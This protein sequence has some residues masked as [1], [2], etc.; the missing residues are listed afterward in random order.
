M[1]D[2]VFFAVYKPPENRLLVFADD[3]QPRWM[4]CN[5]MLD[6]NT[7]AGGDKFGNFF[8]N[9]LAQS[10][11]DMVDADPTGASILHEKGFL[12]GA[13]HKTEM[14]THYNVSPSSGLRTSRSDSLLGRRYPHVDTKGLTS[15]WWS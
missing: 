4:T 2:S 7:I 5:T 13:P 12:M 1:Q 11:T 15:G 3:T 8:V 9:R 10:V 14:L 6:Y